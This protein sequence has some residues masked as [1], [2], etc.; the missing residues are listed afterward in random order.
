[1]EEDEFSLGYS[2]CKGTIQLYLINS[3][4]NLGR[5]GLEM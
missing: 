2:Q 3:K 1:M 5:S 4:L